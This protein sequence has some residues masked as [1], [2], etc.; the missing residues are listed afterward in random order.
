MD[1]RKFL[2]GMGLAVPGY[3]GDGGGRGFFAAVTGC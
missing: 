2:A 1:R 3:G